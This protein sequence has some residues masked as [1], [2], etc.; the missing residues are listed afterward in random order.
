[1]PAPSP[2]SPLPQQVICRSVSMAHACSAPTATVENMRPGALLTMPHLS[3]PQHTSVPFLRTPHAVSAPVAIILYSSAGTTV[4]SAF[5]LPKQ[6]GEP[7]RC[8]PHV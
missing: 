6:M 2:P 7:S 1:M 3:S 8:T 4:L 5:L